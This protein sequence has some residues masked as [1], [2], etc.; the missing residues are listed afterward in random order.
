[1]AAVLHDWLITYGIPAGLITSRDCDG[2]FRRVLREEGT[3]VVRRWLMWTGV[4]LAAPF[5][6]GRR[7][8]GLWR[9]APIVFGISALVLTPPTATAAALVMERT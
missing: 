4:R 7:P 2:M 8:S 5:N 1:M 9:D 3:D 6:P